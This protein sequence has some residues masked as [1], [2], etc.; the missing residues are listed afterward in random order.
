[1]KK[2][3][4]TYYY[5][6]D[7][8]KLEGTVVAA[9]QEEAYVLAELDCAENGIYVADEIITLE[10]LENKQEE[11]KEEAHEEMP[12]T[13]SAILDYLNSDEDEAIDGYEKAI[14]K[15]ENKTAE[16]NN[17]LDALEELTDIDNPKDEDLD[18]LE[19]VEAAIDTLENIAS[20][21]DHIEVEE[22]EHKAELEDAKDD[23]RLASIDDLKLEEA[24]TEAMADLVDEEIE[25]DLEGEALEEAKRN[26]KRYYI[27]PQN[28]Y[29]S[30]KTEI[31]KNLIKLADQNCSIYTLKNLPDNKDLHLLTNKDII[32]YYDDGILYDKNHVKVMDYDLY[33]KH[34]EERK[35][36]PGENG[37]GVSDT[38]FADE[39]DDRITDA[40]LDMEEA[41]ELDEDKIYVGKIK[42][43]MELPSEIHLLSQDE[44]EQL[45]DLLEPEEEFEVGYVSPL[46]FYKEL[47]DILPIFKCT[48]MSGYTGVDFSQS[49]DSVHTD[50]AQRVKD[51]QDQIALAKETGKQVYVGADVNYSNQNKLV[52]QF[53]R[54]DA[55]GSNVVQSTILFY[56][57]SEAKVCYFTKLPGQSQ[58]LKLTA[59]QLEKH[60]YDNLDKIT[61][62]FDL[63]KAKTKVYDTLYGKSVQDID[64]DTRGAAALDPKYIYKYE[65]DKHSVR[66]LYTTQLYMLNISGASRRG[67]S[68]V[69]CLKEDL[70]LNENTTTGLPDWT[71]LSDKEEEKALNLKW[72]ANLNGEVNGISGVKGAHVDVMFKSGRSYVKRF[73][74]ELVRVVYNDKSER[75]NAKIAKDG[76]L[77]NIKTYKFAGFFEPQKFES[78]TSGEIITYYLATKDPTLTSRLETYIEDKKDKKA[79]AKTAAYKGARA[80]SSLTP[81]EKAEALD[82]FAKN[83]KSMDIT[84]P[85]GSPTYTEEEG[86]VDSSN[87]KVKKITDKFIK[88]S[89]AFHNDFDIPESE[90][91]GYLD[92][93]HKVHFGVRDAEKVHEKTLE[94]YTFWGLTCEIEFATSLKDANGVVLGLIEQAKIDSIRAKN[95]VT[96]WK[97]TDTSISSIFLCYSIK[98]L[99]NDDWNLLSKPGQ[100]PIAPEAAKVI[101][102]TEENPFDQE[103]EE[104]N[105]YGE[106][107]TEGKVKGGVCCICGEEIEGYGNNPE[108][109]KHDGRCCDACNLKFVI[110]ARL[111]GIE[112][113]QEEEE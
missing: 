83:I 79:K 112:G 102:N 62:K 89:K 103:F 101:D 2:E 88:I 23:A 41:L 91:E 59:E 58:Y 11:L 98:E 31:I 25:F 28:I 45:I 33:I 56:P 57:T 24:L 15:I 99:V 19:N 35:K 72:A 1:M 46:Y 39:Y 9:N 61:R 70:D 54:T 60:I 55:I 80:V 106:A 87:P 34:E 63:A 50:A 68:L 73:G 93:A 75:L 96:P 64:R 71:E 95:S 36:F 22:E 49:E 38:T 13:L 7:P 65:R 43:E 52:H 44:V 6:T 85:I 42:Q 40:D 82:W 86:V 77:S 111:E 32:Y 90:Q 105:A 12:N 69:E 10:L 26:V 21:L 29:C 92:A 97:E 51:A 66:A 78:K 84:C 94:Y 100:D 3:L 108:P 47:W 27:R 4:H 14:E 67:H 5:I 81:E 76:D 16:L 74:G 17:E 18:R 104:V 37:E 8:H 30:N 110:P 109:I 113:E 107:L 48:E 53:K 20:E